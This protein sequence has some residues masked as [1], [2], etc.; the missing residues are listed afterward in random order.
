MILSQTLTWSKSL[1]CWK[2]RVMPWSGV[3]W[4]LTTRKPTPSMTT[5]PPS[6]GSIPLRRL[7]R[8]DLPEPLGPTTLV[9]PRR[10][11]ATESRSTALT[12]PNSLETSTVSRAVSGWFEASF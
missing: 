5:I 11:M 4:A 8:V 9:I 2:V 3:S 12:P 10:L 6:R 1:T 7:M